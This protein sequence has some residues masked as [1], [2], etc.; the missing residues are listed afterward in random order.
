MLEITDNQDFY[1]NLLKS[2]E[3]SLSIITLYNLFDPY[4]VYVITL[5]IV[6]SLLRYHRRITNNKNH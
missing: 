6:I 4:L 2:M 1:H 5:V 3:I